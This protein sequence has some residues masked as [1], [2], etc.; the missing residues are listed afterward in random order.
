MSWST[1]ENSAAGPEQVASYSAAVDA[2]HAFHDAWASA[3]PGAQVLDQ[4]TADL[5]RW[6]EALT[7]MAVPEVDRLSGRITSLPVR[8]HLAVPPVLVDVVTADRVEGTVTFGPFFLGGGGAAHGGTILTVFDEVLGMQASAGGRG[9]ARTAYMRT[10][11]R[12]VV[13]IGDPI[14]VRTRLEREDGRKR[15]VRGELW[16][17]ETLCAETEALFIGLRND[18]P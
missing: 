16:A 11:F 6:T 10:D 18:T 13:P 2:L 15:Y 12:A 5:R 1:F 4:I 3:A 8:G 9:A 7:P 17:G 14:V